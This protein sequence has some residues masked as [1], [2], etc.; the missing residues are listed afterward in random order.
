MPRQCGQTVLETLQLASQLQRQQPALTH[1]AGREHAE[2]YSSESLVQPPQPIMSH[3]CAR[4]DIGALQCTQRTEKIIFIEHTGSAAVCSKERRPEAAHSRRP[5]SK[6]PSWGRTLSPLC[7]PSSAICRVLTTDSGYRHVVKPCRQRSSKAARWP[8]RDTLG[9]AA[10]RRP[11]F[12]ATAAHPER[13]L[14]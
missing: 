1:H 2:H 3:H 10:V 7:D 8:V 14:P 11:V 6:L 4:S 5:L 9:G 13:C 12:G